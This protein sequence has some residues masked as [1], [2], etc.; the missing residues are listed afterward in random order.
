M[1][2]IQTLNTISDKG[3]S[4]LEADQYLT[5]AEIENPDAYL[6]RS[7]SLHERELPAQLKVIARAGAGVDNIP[8]DRCTAAGVPVF[9]T[10]GANANAVKEMVIAGLLLSSRRICEGVEWVRSNAHKGEELPAL[11]EREKRRFGGPEIAGKTLGVVGLGSVG[12]LVCNA[13]EQLGMRVIGYD[14]Y[15]SIPHA[16]D[17][18]QSVERADELHRLYELSDYISIH[19]PLN[20]TTRNM[21]DEDSIK[22][23]KYGVRILNLSREGLVRHSALAAALKDGK[24]ACYMSDLPESGLVGL[25][26]VVFT[27]HIGASTPEAEDNCA[28]T[29]V[30][31][32]KTYLET[33]NIEH[34]VN[35]PRCSMDLGGRHRITIANRNVPNMVGQIT[36]LL[37]TAGHN[38]EDLINKHRDDV[39]YNI[40]D[41]SE[42]P[43]ERTMGRLGSI[44][45]VLAA[46]LVY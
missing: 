18:S 9:N 41:L 24:V 8:L 1:Y 17:L 33:G 19:V 32:L 42:A 43:N 23:M 26:S 36:T 13:A 40:I 45:G 30:R 35:F 16:W 21:I 29:A 3:L 38:I 10:P 15:I 11:V 4:L 28:V 39:A 7:S 37:A 31:L 34:S 46:R 2:R 22:A 25:E 12:V 20:D 14:P 5:G 44:E 27:P 6:I